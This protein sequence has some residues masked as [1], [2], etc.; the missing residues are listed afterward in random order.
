MI[1]VTGATGLIGSFLLRRLLLEGLPFVALKRKGADLSG[2]EDIK[3][4]VNWKEADILDEVALEEAFAGCDSVIHAAAMV[5]FNPRD[6]EKLFQ[7][8]TVGTKHVVNTCLNLGINKL[9]YISSVAALGRSKKTAI[10]DESS[11]W[12]NSSLNTFYGESKYLAELEVWRGK[13]EGMEVAVINPSV[14][15][16]PGNWDKSSAKI[17]KYIWKE[18]PFYTT[19]SFNYIDVRDLVD[20]IMEANKG[21]LNG[22]RII[23]SAGKISYHD[24][25]TMA[26]LHFNKKAPNIKIGSRFILFLALIEHIRSRLTGSDPLITP[27]TARLAHAGIVFDNTKIKNVMSFDFRSLDDTLRWCSSKYVDQ[28]RVA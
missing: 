13:E 22:E 28:L 14:V 16:A 26:A 24:F 23:A 15:L 2:M 17:F 3:D 27:E 1:A 20:I 8:N 4:Q 6:R 5:S 25:L 11:Q 9:V 18:K 21:R 12:T 7:T 10:I 19:G